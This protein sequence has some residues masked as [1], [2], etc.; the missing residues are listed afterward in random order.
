MVPKYHGQVTGV[1][2]LARGRVDRVGR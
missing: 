2:R 1:V